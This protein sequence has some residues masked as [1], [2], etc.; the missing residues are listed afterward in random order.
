VKRTLALVAHSLQRGRA[1]LLGF[2]WLLGGFQVLAGLMASTFQRSNTFGQIAAIVPPF[3][4]ELFGQSMFAVL[5]FQ[6][7]VCLGYFHPIPIGALIAVTVVFATEPSAEIERRFVDLVLARPVARAAIV[8]RTILV[9]LVA[10][11]I[12][13][14]LM[15]LGTWVGL[16]S[17]AP[18]DAIRP[19]A[20]LLRALGVNLGAL[21]LAWGGI[22]LAIAAR[23]RRR[24]VAGAIVGLL[25]FAAFLLDYMARLWASARR[26]AWLSPFHYYDPMEMLLGSPPDSAHVWTL[27]AIAVVGFALAYVGFSRRD[28]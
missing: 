5:S 7:V 24:G 13:V 28:L 6:G 26:F 15:W 22:A 11:A 23:A 20:S 27:L 1:L 2:G 19:P 8:T 16:A 21:A 14:G 17:F 12:V 18:Q 4:R 25:A 9:L 10:I 3:V